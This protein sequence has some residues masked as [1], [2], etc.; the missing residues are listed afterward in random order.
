MDRPVLA[1]LQHWRLLVL[2]GDLGLWLTAYAYLPWP[3]NSVVWYVW[4]PADS[5]EMEHLVTPRSGES[6]GPW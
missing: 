5:Y 6:A 2:L 1:F 4:L 3:W